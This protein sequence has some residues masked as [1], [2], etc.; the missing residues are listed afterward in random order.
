VNKPFVA[1]KLKF[2]FLYGP[3]FVSE[4]KLCTPNIFPL[5]RLHLIP[6]GTGSSLQPVSSE[7]VFVP[8]NLEM[9]FVRQTS[10]KRVSQQTCS[11]L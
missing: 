4:Y 3:Y 2:C 5:K 10:V 1:L 6:L 7:L 9:A 11:N 8:E